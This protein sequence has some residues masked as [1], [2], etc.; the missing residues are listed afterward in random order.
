LLRLGEWGAAVRFCAWAGADGVLAG[1]R[2]AE[3][4]MQD[5][6]SG[7]VW[8][9]ADPAPP[10]RWR[11]IQPEAIK[12]LCWQGA[13]TLLV[14]ASPA[15]AA[16]L[17]QFAAARKT[18]SSSIVGAVGSVEAYW[19]Q[20]APTRPEPRGRR[21][22]QPLMAISTPPATAPDPWVRPA[23][24]RELDLVTP[25][26]VAMFTE[27]LGFPP[28]GAD[29]P[30]RMHVAQLITKGR[31]FVRFDRGGTAPDRQVLFK[32][33]LGAVMAKAAQIQG[34]WTH[35]DWRG[36]GLA[37]SG[38]ATVVQAARGQGVEQVS[39]Y[40]N[41]FNAPA[42]ATYRAVGFSQVDTWATIML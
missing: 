37:K 10:G 40:V 15:H 28:P 6:P 3:S 4:W 18:T 26:A 41:G 35:P 8:V 25:A 20:L 12:A 38:L 7:E 29:G 16:A 24:T 14:G 39:L 21:M 1:A 30:Y 13:N 33:D 19:S 31:S 27:E 5:H 2:I 9:V 22:D 42:M 34:V 32:A 17:G 11:R 36:R 23:T